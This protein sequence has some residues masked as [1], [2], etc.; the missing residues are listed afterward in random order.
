MF[1]GTDFIKTSNRKI[2]PGYIAVTILCLMRS[3]IFIYE[4]GR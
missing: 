2:Q 3:R 1:A 4:P